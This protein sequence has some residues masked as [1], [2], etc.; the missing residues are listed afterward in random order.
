V[1]MT[2]TTVSVCPQ[3]LDEKFLE[4]L[5]GALEN[6]GDDVV[7]DLSL[8][9]RVDASGLKA[10]ESL[11]DTAVEKNVKVRLQGVSV[12]VYK[13]LKLVKLTRRFTC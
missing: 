10:L 2:M 7:L 6:A 12:E 4:T 11:A 13:V 5:R 3:L 8:I 9:R 1:C